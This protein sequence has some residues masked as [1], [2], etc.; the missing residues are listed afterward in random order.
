MDRR[1]NLGTREAN[2]SQRAIVEL[3]KPFNGRATGDMVL[4][5]IQTGAEKS[6]ECAGSPGGRRPQCWLL[7]TFLI[8]YGWLAELRRDRLDAVN[9]KGLRP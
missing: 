1:F 6:G 2:V 5:A 7:Q 8:S 9:E 3:P 4:D